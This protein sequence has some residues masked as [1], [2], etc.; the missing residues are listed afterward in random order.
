[1]C[2]CVLI[3]TFCITQPANTSNP[4]PTQP[5]PIPNATPQALVH[6]IGHPTSLP[7]A[8][9]A[10]IAPVPASLSPE[11]VP[12]PRRRQGCIPFVQLNPQ[13]SATQTRQGRAR[14]SDSAIA[15]T[16][17]TLPKRPTRRTDSTAKEEYARPSPPS[18][19]TVVAPPP[20]ERLCRRKHHSCIPFTAHESEE[21][22]PQ[23]RKG[24]AKR[25]GVATAL[26]YLTI[27]TDSMM[28]ARRYARNACSSP[29]ATPHTF[30]TSGVFEPFILP[31]SCGGGNLRPRTKVSAC[32]K[33]TR[34][35]SLDTDS[36]TNSK[37]T[38]PRKRRS[39]LP[40]SRTH[41][42]AAGERLT[43]QPYLR[44]AYR[45]ADDMFR[46]V[47][48]ELGLGEQTAFYSP[49]EWCRPPSGHP[50]LP[51]WLLGH[52][53]DADE[54]QQE[55]RVK[56]DSA[57][58]ADFRMALQNTAPTETCCV[59]SCFVSPADCNCIPLASVPALYL[60]RADLPPT[61]VIPRSGH[62]T[63]AYDG[64]TYL[65]QPDGIT[66]TSGTVMAQVCSE[67]LASLSGRKPKVPKAS[68]AAIDPGTAPPTLP[69]LTV[70]E[71]IIIAP[72]RLI[73]HV[74]TLTPGRRQDSHPERTEDS[75]G[76]KVEWTAASTGHTVTFRNPG[77][78]A[79]LR[80]FPMPAADIPNI[81]KVSSVNVR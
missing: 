53:S 73:C 36:D 28:H 51:A 81:F 58:A 63:Y 50:D 26:D 30:S 6:I 15:A 2:V 77:P 38:T 78:D 10:A 13:D 56:E 64:V 71:S 1:M 62:T 37:Q 34:T 33:R 76:D 69:N 75:E 31:Q 39:N 25:S 61:D 67:C 57:R 12:R 24:R 11:E 70:M 45:D 9:P 44:P 17:V 18:A 32:T 65:L 72:T 16:L 3:T 14:C 60:L 43:D 4:A 46:L 20:Q 49:S 41:N 19:A 8:V 59:C 55:R 40:D 68:L 48:R 66:T 22:A 74:L 5:L 47:E 29:P 79:F 52:P 80:T 35:T 21:C 54:S 42:H 27:A 23:T 7:V